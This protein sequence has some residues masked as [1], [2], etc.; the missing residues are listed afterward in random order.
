M[1]VIN[2]RYEFMMVDVGDYGRLSDCSV[3]SSS[4]LGY[5]R[6]NNLL[7]IPKESVIPGTN[8]YFPYVFVGDDAFPLR[9]YLV[10]PYPRRTIR[11]REKITN[12]RI[13]RA[14]RIVENAF[15]IARFKVFRREITAYVESFIQVCVLK[16]SL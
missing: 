1:A 7:N 13:S 4:K 3:Y 2:A 16:W 6:N 14:Q 8:N 9:I 10:K 5:D 11:L 12:Y 15:R